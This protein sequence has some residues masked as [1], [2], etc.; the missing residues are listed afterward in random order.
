VAAV[1]IP[2]EEISEQTENSGIFPMRKVA[3]TM[4]TKILAKANIILFPKL[5]C[6]K[7]SRSFDND[8]DLQ[9]SYSVERRV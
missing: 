7:Q 1:T 6:Q 5:T 2:L 9:V 4:K 8:E 3:V